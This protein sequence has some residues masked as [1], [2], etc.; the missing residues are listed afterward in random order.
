LQTNNLQLADNHLTIHSAKRAR[1]KDMKKT[2][3]P[4][5]ALL[6]VGTFAPAADRADEMFEVIYAPQLNKASQL[7]RLKSLIDEGAD[8]N[9]PINFDRMLR[10][11]ETRADLRPTGWP[12]DAAVEQARLDMVKLLLANGAKFHGGELTKAALAGNHDESLAMVTVLLQAGADVN[13]RHDSFT[14]LHW[15]SYKGNQ[16]TVKLLLAQPGLKLDDTNIDG[17]TALMAAAEQGH[18]E[19]VEMLLKAG[20]NASTTLIGGETAA[21][22]AQKTLAKQQAVV[23]KQQRIISRLRSK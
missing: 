13:S 11:G 14:A 19:I 8:V 12:L 10:V 15:A 20:A 2:M 7:A 1:V 4:I 16:N 17:R 21:A 18:A 22:L 6:T 3:L 23:E 9:A 5:I